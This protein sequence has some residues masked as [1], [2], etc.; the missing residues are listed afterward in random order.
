MIK[1]R[2]EFTDINETYEYEGE[3]IVFAIPHIENDGIE[4]LKGAQGKFTIKTLKSVQKILKK[5]FKDIYK[6]EGRIE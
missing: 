6:G 1:V 5:M 3:G 4:V 2:I